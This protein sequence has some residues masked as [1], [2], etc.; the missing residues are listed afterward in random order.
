MIH[1]FEELKARRR[2]ESEH[3][4]AKVTKVPGKMSND[5]HSATMRCSNYCRVLKTTL[6]EISG[7]VQLKDP[8][9]PYVRGV[10]TI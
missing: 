2:K 1:L 10:C 6:I 3:L 7:L 9:F 4:L 5:R 8:D